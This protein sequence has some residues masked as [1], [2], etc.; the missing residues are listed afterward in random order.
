MVEYIVK[1]TG[2]TRAGETYPELSF[3]D[4]PALDTL[5]ASYNAYI[6]NLAIAYEAATGFSREELFGEAVLALMKAREDFQDGLSA[7]NS[8]FFKFRIIDALNEYVRMNK[9]TVDVPK[10]ISRANNIIRRIKNILK[11]DDALFASIITGDKPEL[12]EEN[13]DLAEEYRLLSAAAER[14]AVSVE[15]LVQRSE[16]LPIYSEDIAEESSSYDTQDGLLAKLVV[17]KIKG[18]LSEGE[19]VVAELLMDGYSLSDI[20]RELGKYPS[21]AYRQ[22]KSIRKKVRTIL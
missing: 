14:A 13:K 7:N 17:E 18:L 3:K 5:L 9:C 20:D 6:N 19:T 4:L 1:H 11:N 2:K 12:L 15:S 22:L 8:T 21:W 16:F 10:Y